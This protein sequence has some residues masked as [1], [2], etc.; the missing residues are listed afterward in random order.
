MPGDV[1]GKVESQEDLVWS[2]STEKW[3]G[4]GSKGGPS[5]LIQ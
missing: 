5:V 2:V 1:V 3:V 4:V